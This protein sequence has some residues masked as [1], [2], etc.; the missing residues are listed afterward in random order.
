[1]NPSVP[2]NPD[3]VSSADFVGAVVAAE[4]LLEIG[5]RNVASSKPRNAV[6]KRVAS[7]LVQ[8]LQAFEHVPEPAG[9]KYIGDLLA[10]L[11][12]P[13]FDPQRFHLPADD[14]L[15]FVRIDAD[16]DFRIGTRNAEQAAGW[17]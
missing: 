17:R 16:P 5:M 7:W 2:A 4:Q 14:T 6:R 9:R 12:D 10:D 1:M 11:G 13:R 15:G 3:T 8:G